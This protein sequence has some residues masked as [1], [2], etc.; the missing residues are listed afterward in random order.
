MYG[1]DV[2]KTVVG[3][4]SNAMTKIFSNESASSIP[5]FHLHHQGAGNNNVNTNATLWRYYNDSGTKYGWI[6]EQI[7][8]SF[9]SSCVVANATLNDCQS[10]HVLL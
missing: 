2:D 9:R 8:T 5:N 10:C 1:D 3:I 7:E 4:C 6:L